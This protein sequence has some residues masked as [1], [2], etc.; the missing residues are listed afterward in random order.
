MPQKQQQKKHWM[1]LPLSLWGISR[2]KIYCAEKEEEALLPHYKGGELKK[3]ELLL[4]YLLREDKLL[5]AAVGG[6]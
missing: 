3:E 2:G 1:L 4:K 5:M 6:S